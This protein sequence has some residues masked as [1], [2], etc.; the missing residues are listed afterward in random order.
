MHI[1]DQKFDEQKQMFS[2]KLQKQAEKIEDLR[3][4]CVRYQKIIDRLSL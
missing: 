2:E 4:T 1:F 3:E